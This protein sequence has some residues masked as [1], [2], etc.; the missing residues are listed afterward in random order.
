MDM[1]K[2]IEVTGNIDEQGHLHLRDTLPHLAAGPVRIIVLV[3]EEEE[4]DENEWLRNAARNPVFDYLNDPAEDI[5]T[6]S[7][8]K[9]FNDQE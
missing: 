1:M 8:G 5:Y 2:A 3:P 9:P 6:L 7:D 4:I